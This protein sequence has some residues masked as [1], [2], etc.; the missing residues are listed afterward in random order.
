MRI[1]CGMFLAASVC[2]AA[3][4]DDEQCPISENVCGHENIEWS[5]SYAYGLTDETCGLP[6]VLLVGDS[7]CNGY[8]GGVRERLKGKMN[9]TYWVSSYCVTSPA[10]LRLLSIYLDEAKYDVIH[11][12]NGHHSHSKTSAEVYAKGL[13]AAF[14][15]IRRKQPQAK[16]VW[17]STTPLKSATMTARCRER[18]KVAAKVVEKLGG[19]AV[20]DLFAICDPLDRD[21]NWKDNHHFLPAAVAMQAEQVSESVLAACSDCAARTV[22]VA[23]DNANERRDIADVPLSGNG[24]ELLAAGVDSAIGHGVPRTWEV[25]DGGISNSTGR[26]DGVN[27][28]WIEGEMW[29]GKPTRIFAWWGLPADAG[30]DR[31]VPAMVLVHGGGGTAFAS[32]VKRWTDRGYAAIAMDTCGGAPRGEK[33]GKPHPRHAWSGPYGWDDARGYP[34]GPLADQWPYQAVTAIIRCHSF[35]RSLP[36]VDAERTGITGIS[37]GGYLTSVTMGVDHRFKFAAPVYGCGWYDL[38]PAVWKNVAG[39]GDK[40]LRW[41][42]NWD[43][44]HYIGD[45]LC[46]VLRCNGNLDIFYTMEMTR[47]STEALPKSTPSY[48]SIKHKMAHGHPPAGDPKE[49]AAWAD[50]YLKG[51]ARPLSV[52]E[53]KMSDG[54]MAVR[55]DPGD[56]EAVS[57]ELLYTKEGQPSSP[58][59]RFSDSREWIVVPIDGFTRG[60]TSVS[61]DVPA[62]ALIFFVNVKTAAGL[63]ATTPIVESER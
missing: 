56:E 59:V 32:W 27:P 8:Q 22:A 10:Y 17:C 4:G 57:A 42:D 60:A 18:N 14:E 54:R 9:V 1:A 62:E 30:V 51:W 28:I 2:F 34:D 26:I 37:W 35:I 15:L 40:F 63:V 55:I 20:D 11:F 49:I 50:Y 39:G 13:E 23:Q 36:E 43:A 25:T 58:D 31:K 29:K 61:V 12:N 46:P 5:R 33:D 21:S 45:T 52:I 44:K 7:I 38:N 41:L 19:I 6:R 53:A 16:L 48:L 3:L 47:R 24:K